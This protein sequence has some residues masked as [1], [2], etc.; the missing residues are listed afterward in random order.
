MHISC[1]KW[2]GLFSLS[3]F[4]KLNLGFPFLSHKR[5]RERERGLHAMNQ[6][7]FYVQCF[8]DS[9]EEL[10]VLSIPKTSPFLGKYQI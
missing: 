10:W 4:I 6:T 8:L 3:F 1:F 9:K 2:W 7:L 5:G